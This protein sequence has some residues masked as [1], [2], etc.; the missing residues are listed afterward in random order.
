MSRVRPAHRSICTTS[1]LK[2]DRKNY[3]FNEAWS[4]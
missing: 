2:N 4:G 1:A 3:G